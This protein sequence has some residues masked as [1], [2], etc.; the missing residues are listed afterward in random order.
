MAAVG[1][2]ML[3]TYPW[4]IPVLVPAIIFMWRR[5]RRANQAGKLP[6]PSPPPSGNPD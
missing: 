3:A 4:T 1:I 2:A 6:P 5:E